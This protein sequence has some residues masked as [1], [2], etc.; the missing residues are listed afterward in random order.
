MQNGNFN[1]MYLI[2][3]LTGETTD[4]LRESSYNFMTSPHDYLTRFYIVFD[5]TD[6]DEFVDDEDDS[7]IYFN[8]SGWVVEGQ[9]HLDVVDV[10]GHVLYSTELVDNTTEVN[11][12]QYAK[13]VY[14]MRLTTEHTQRTQRIVNIK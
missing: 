7:F 2:D 5:V 13:G 8:G 14:L 10:T 4:M 11:L 9:G 3:N 6:V 12:N 1:T